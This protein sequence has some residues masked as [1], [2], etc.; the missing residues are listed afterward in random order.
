MIIIKINRMD[1]DI[2]DGSALVDVIIRHFTQKVKKC[3]NLWLRVN[4]FD[5]R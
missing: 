3:F 1:E 4:D 2:D 5:F